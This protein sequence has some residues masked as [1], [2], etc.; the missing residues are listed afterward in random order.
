MGTSKMH[1]NTD[2]PQVLQLSLS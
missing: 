2:I 1:F